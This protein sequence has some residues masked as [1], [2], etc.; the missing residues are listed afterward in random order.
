[1]EWEAILALASY[2][3]YDISR[4]VENANKNL[5]P[6]TRFGLQ[7][8]SESDTRYTLELLDRLDRM[9]GSRWLKEFESQLA[10][11]KAI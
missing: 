2:A 3:G 8:S 7:I 5:F 11:A 9:D 6:D 1:M 4:E 10:A